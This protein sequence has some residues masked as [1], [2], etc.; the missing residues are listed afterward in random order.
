[1]YTIISTHQSSVCHL[2]LMGFERF[3]LASLNLDIGDKPVDRESDLLLQHG[4]DPR[5]RVVASRRV[6]PGVV[7]ACQSPSAGLALRSSPLPGCS[8]TVR[9]DSWSRAS[10]KMR[11]RSA[12]GVQPI[13]GPLQPE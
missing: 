9:A 1:L 11:V 12:A 3:H 4:V 2:H 13:R 10:R 5:G 8:S 7:S 6:L